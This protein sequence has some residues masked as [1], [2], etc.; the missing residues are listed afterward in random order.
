MKGGHLGHFL[1]KLP[2][3]KESRPAALASYLVAK[4]CSVFL[5]LNLFLVI[6]LPFR[7]K[8][9]TNYPSAQ[10]SAWVMCVV[11]VLGCHMLDLNHHQKCVH[12]GVFNCT[13]QIKVKQK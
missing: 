2:S 10:P 13:E 11:K 6:E 12:N 4:N 1:I 9:K 8:R 5:K 3:S 7:G